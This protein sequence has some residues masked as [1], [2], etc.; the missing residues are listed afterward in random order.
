L[1]DAAGTTALA[2]GTIGRSVSNALNTPYTLLF[3]T[4]FAA[5]AGTTYSIWFRTTAAYSPA[6]KIRVNATSAPANR[7]PTANAGPD[8]TVASAASVS[9]TGAGST[10]P[11]AGQT[12]SYAWSQTGEAAVTLTGNT[13]VA[14]TFTAPTLNAGNADVFLTFSLI[15]TD[16]FS[17]TPNVR[18][19][20]RCSTFL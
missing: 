1:G 2:T 16:S 17:P 9:L 15:V 18:D 12:L 8:Q 4:P 5:S 19:V 11:D 10:D 7:A 13:T 14:P 3:G 6:T 20:V